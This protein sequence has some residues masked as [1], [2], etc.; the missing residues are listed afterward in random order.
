MDVP[1]FDELTRTLG[2]TTSRRQVLKGVAAAVVGGALAGLG[3]GDSKQAEAFGENTCNGV[4]YDPAHQCCEPSGIQQRYPI[5]DIEACP[6][7]VPHPGYTATSNGCGPENGFFKYVVPNRL[8]PLRNIDFTP[9]CNGHDIC[10]GTCNSDKSSCDQHFFLDMSKA[11]ANAYPNDT[12]YGRYM[13]YSCVALAR[14]YYTAVSSTRTGTSA[15]ATAQRDACDCCPVC[16]DCDGPTDKCCDS[17]CVDVSNDAENC[18]DCGT[19]CR[20]DQICADSTCQCPSGETECN[21]VCVDL[22]SDPA[23]CGACGNACTSGASCFDGI[24]GC[25][26]AMTRCDGQCVDLTGNHDHCGSCDTACSSCEECV[27]GT[28][29]PM[30]CENACLTCQDGECVSTCGAGLQCCDDGSCK[31]QCSDCPLDRI[32]GDVCCDEGDVCSE[33][34]DCIP[35]ACATCADDEICCNAVGLD[36]SG[37]GDGMTWQCRKTSEYKICP[38]TPSAGVRGFYRDAWICCPVDSDCC[39]GNGYLYS[40]CGGSDGICC[41]AGTSEC[42]SMCCDFVWDDRNHTCGLDEDNNRV[43]R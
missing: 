18:G 9:A 3:I 2:Q 25:P 8:G 43:C 21:G 13:V 22:N 14:L 34:T 31:E 39:G 17:Q 42:A 11:C 35:S 19:S 27:D 10:Y 32:C 37:G 16:E 5:R 15:Y 29:Q 6:D 41:P 36:A 1:R 20:A 7:R 23:N 12:W 4:P 38:V 40:V 28:C 24:C 30:D 26:P 33:G